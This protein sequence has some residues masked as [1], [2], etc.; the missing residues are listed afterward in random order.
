MER[1]P[2]MQIQEINLRSGTVLP[3]NQPPSPPTNCEEEREESIPRLNPPPFLERLT[4]RVR[5][6]PEENE[7]LGEL[8][9]LCVK[10]PLLQAIKIVPI[11]NKLIKEK[12]FKHPRN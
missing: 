4:H 11:Y 5:P 7:L 9:N 8:K 2:T 1:H 10:I 6:T 12:C 3:D